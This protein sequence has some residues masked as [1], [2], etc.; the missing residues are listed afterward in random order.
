[1]AT[2]PEGLEIAPTLIKLLAGIPRYLAGAADIEKF[3]RETWQEELGACH[4]A[5]HGIIIYPFR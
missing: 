3:A 2:G 4:V 5:H 1:M